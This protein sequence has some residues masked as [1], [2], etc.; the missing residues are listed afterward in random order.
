MDGGL[1]IKAEIYP[2]FPPDLFLVM[3][4]TTAESKLEQRETSTIGRMAT[5][6]TPALPDRLRGRHSYLQ[7]ASFLGAPGNPEAMHK[8]MG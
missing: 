5:G 8:F 3:A 6:V 7:T 4:F 1:E 2:F